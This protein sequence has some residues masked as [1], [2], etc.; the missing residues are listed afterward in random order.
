MDNDKIKNIIEAL[1]ISAEE[2]LTIEQIQQVLESVTPAII[3]E[4]IDRLKKDYLDT[5]RSFKINEI[6]GGYQIATR[7]EF[8]PYLRKLYNVKHVERLSRPSLETLAIIAYKQ[9]VTRLDIESIRGVNVDGVLRSLSEKNL[10]KI[11]GRKEV[12]GRP[13]IYGTSRLFLE[14]FGLNSLEDLPDIEKFKQTADEIFKRREDNFKEKE[15]E[16]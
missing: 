11:K 3:K 12:V 6:A 14:Y 10:I 15:D 7:E 1:L 4:Q 5:N 2:A 13:Y 9:P 8:A 16:S